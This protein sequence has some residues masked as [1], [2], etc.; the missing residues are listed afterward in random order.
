MLF[1]HQPFLIYVDSWLTNWCSLEM[2]LKFFLDCLMALQKVLLLCLLAIRRPSWR[3]KNELHWCLRESFIFND[4]E[5]SFVWPWLFSDLRDTICSEPLIDDVCWHENVRHDVVASHCLGPCWRHARWCF[6]RW[7]KQAYSWLI[8]GGLHPAS[9]QNP[10]LSLGKAQC[11][12]VFNVAHSLSIFSST[13]TAVVVIS[14]FVGS[15][16]TLNR[17]SLYSFFPAKC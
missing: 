5:M 6:Q 10:R 7:W 16:Q 12:V 2:Q 11:Y 8:Q 1:F 15:Y 17:H 14:R 3:S 4:L 13:S 9:H